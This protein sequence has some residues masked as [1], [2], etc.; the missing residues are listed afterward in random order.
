VDASK[1][2]L[3]SDIIPVLQ[4]R[5]INDPWLPRLQTFECEEATK[6]FIPFIPSLLS[7]KTTKIMID[8][9]EVTPI[10]VVASTIVRLSKLCPDLESITLDDLPRDPI[11]TEAVSEMLLACNRNTLP[12]FYVDSPLLNGGGARGCLPAS[13]IIQPMGGYPGTHTITHGGIAKSH[14]S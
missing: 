6:A 13:Q 7:P 10:V 8:S 4:L 9:D 14:F 11:I 1:D 3:S 12:K 2:P 5:A